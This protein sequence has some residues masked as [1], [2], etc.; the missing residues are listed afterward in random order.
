MVGDGSTG[1]GSLW[2]EVIQINLIECRNCNVPDCTGCNIHRLSVALRRGLLDGL[3]D[4][5]NGIR[6]TSEI[7][8]VRHG[9]W[10]GDCKAISD[11]DGIARCGM[12]GFR[13]SKCNGFSIEDGRYCPN[14]GAKM[15]SGET[16]E[17]EINPCRGCSDYDEDG[18]CLSNGGCLSYGEEY[19]DWSHYLEEK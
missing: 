19:D 8:P 6:I 3:K 13:C 2:V 12:Y 10:I 11:A 1:S 16:D 17:P 4:K 18:G 9:E 7:E 5:H 14:C 15:N